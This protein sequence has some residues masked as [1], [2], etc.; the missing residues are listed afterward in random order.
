VRL[1]AQPA[2]ALALVALGGLVGASIPATV[3]GVGPPPGLV[4][5][6]A[7]GCVVAVL[8]LRADPAW[9]LSGAIAASMFSGHWGD[10]GSPLPLDRALLL[11]AVAG[12]VL[13]LPIRRPAG[14]RP[15]FVDVAIAAAALFATA[16]AFSHG[17]SLHGEGLFALLDRFGLI[18]LAC[19]LLA[20]VVFDT[21]RRRAILLGF[22]V[23]CGAYLG[24]TALAESAGGDALVWP[25]YIADASVGIH[26]D[27]ARGPF[28][29]APAM[30]TALWACAVA[31]SMLVAAP[32]RP[33]VRTVGLTVA[34]LC[35][36]GVF[37]TL[38][39]TVW[40]GA[41]VA[42]VV[43][44]GLTRGLRPYLVPAALA[45]A[46]LV[47]GAMA[48][49]PGLADRA[50]ERQGDEAPIWDRRNSN[51]A[52]LRMLNARPLLG[53]GWD[54]FEEASPPY[55]R[56]AFDY[57]L[58]AVGE[59]HNVFLSNLAELGLIG[60]SLWLVALLVAVGAPLVRPPPG[61]LHPWRVGLVA[62]ATLWVIAAAFDPLPYVFPNLLLWTWAGVLWVRPR[63]AGMRQESIA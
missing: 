23:A 21:P 3:L 48:T 59:V 15:R 49:L 47:V 58:T 19:F 40:V 44:F 60:T 30:G 11:L 37:L 51:T 31:A 13:R 52:A 1:P 9:S 38:T 17:L 39:R 33:W 28:V 36:L 5:F 45:G 46:L 25:R 26:A 27:R 43:T 10:L 16:S 63:T 61:G 57:P 42:T 14:L 41:V 8:A 18:P 2:T 20:P 35:A 22:L 24:L 55:Y 56:Q 6:G 12:L 53:F 29:S 54:R 4:V 34:A 62:M 50:R 32:P 7:A